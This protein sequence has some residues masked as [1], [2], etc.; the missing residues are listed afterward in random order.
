MA[1]PNGD[2]QS[3]WQRAGAAAAAGYRNIGGKRAWS[4]F[5]AGW[6]GPH[7]L[8]GDQGTQ[9]PQEQAA[10][11]GRLQTLGLVPE[12]DYNRMAQAVAAG[13]REAQQTTGGQLGRVGGTTQGGHRRGRSTRFEAHRYPSLGF[14]GLLS[15]V[16]LWAGNQLVSGP[17]E[18][19]PGTGGTQ[20][21]PSAAPTTGGVA[22]QAPRPGS[23]QSQPT[24]PP[25]AT[26]PPPPAPPGPQMG[27]TTTAQLPPP[28]PV[29]ASEAGE[30]AATT[31]VG[32]ETAEAAAGTTAGVG[33]AAAAGGLANMLGK[34]LLGFGAGGGLAG[35]WE[36]LAGAGGASILGPIGLAGT[37]VTGLYEG[38]NMIGNAIAGQRQL[39]AYWQGMLGGN[40]WSGEAQRAQQAGFRLS[41]LGNL[42]GAQANALFQGV[43]GLDM[44]GAQ[45]TNAMNQA[46]QMYD[47]LG[48]SIQSSIQ[49]ITIA[50][51]SGNKELAGLADAIDNVTQAAVAGGVNANVARQNFTNLYAATTQNVQGAGAVA[52]AS[53]VTAAQTGMGQLLQGANLAGFTS[54]QSMMLLAN[55]ARNPNGTPMTYGQ[56]VGQIELGNTALYGQALR[57]SLQQ[58]LGNMNV[59]A[60]MSQAARAL[61]NQPGYQGIAERL[62]RGQAT[63]TDL[64]NIAAE[65]Q[66]QGSNLGLILPQYFASMY[67]VNLSS[68]QAMDLALGTFTGNF[69]PNTRTPTAGQGAL[70]QRR[71]TSPS[72]GP[73]SQAQVMSP[74]TADLNRTLQTYVNQNYPAS[75]RQ[76]ILEEGRRAIQQMSTPAGRA[77]G[78]APGASGIYAGVREAWQQEYLKQVNP[79]SAAAQRAVGMPSSISQAWESIFGAT[80]SNAAR[81]W[82]IN[83]VVGKQGVR[84]PV[85][86]KLLKNPELNQYGT[87]FSVDTGQGNKP[88]LATAEELEQHFM[89]AVQSGQV[90]VAS[91]QNANLI[92]QNIAQVLGIQKQS[93]E[94][95]SGTRWANTQQGQAAQKQL[96]QQVTAQQK[97]IVTVVPSQSLLQWM[98]F[99]ANQ[100][101]NVAIDTNTATNQTGPQ[102]PLP[103]LPNT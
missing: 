72:R 4:N 32:V 16:A 14:T 26:P 30:G 57:S 81:E 77:Q 1:E 99:Q 100:G 23:T 94:V 58:Y 82:Y 25:Q 38:A 85:M 13:V 84:D 43:T 55:Q 80:S 9:E 24:P 39:G 15:T 22:G 60:E 3:V 74:T 42:S 12:I 19:A 54:Q 6:V 29:A 28:P 66:A 17:G 64:Q 21:G 86:E 65:M 56:F 79:A 27:T 31:A 51:Q 49:N 10:A 87:V 70:A 89:K 40:I 44:T 103:A 83:N 78:L 48:V 36:G 62:T 68:S 75:Q 47:Q 41:Q 92:G 50:A 18:G 93:K 52:I 11:M 90:T 101:S 96:Q 8:P 46:I 71:I 53:G 5:K 76:T 69:N 61:N 20:G 67:G 37:A 91:S 95:V 45:R 88:I 2:Q 63:Q 73:T 35:A 97:N 98:Q 102:Y 59:P 7:P 34:G 33:E